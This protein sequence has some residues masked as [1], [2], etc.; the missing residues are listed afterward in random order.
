MQFEVFDVMQEG[1]K[2]EVKSTLSSRREGR[3]VYV[4]KRKFDQQLKKGMETEEKA[5][6]QFRKDAP[7]MSLYVEEEKTTDEN[8]IPSSIVRV[9]TQSSLALPVEIL[10]TLVSEHKIAKPMRVR[11]T[12]MEGR[13]TDERQVVITKQLRMRTDSRW[14]GVN[15]QVTYVSDLDMVRI[16]FTVC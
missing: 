14:I 6:D 12:S 3:T 11:V 15:V 2:M 4:P 1:K 5:Y 10:D 13:S 7:R 9:C 8:L 16:D